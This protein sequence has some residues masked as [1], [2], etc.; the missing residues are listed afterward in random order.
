[1]GGD[2]QAQLADTEARLLEMCRGLDAGASAPHADAERYAR[3]GAAIHGIPRLLLLDHAINAVT[4]PLTQHPCIARLR[5]DPQG[6]I[7]TESEECHVLRSVNDNPGISSN[8][9]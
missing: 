2:S 7:S 9:P 5:Q 6:S 3:V 1:M 4:R 8:S